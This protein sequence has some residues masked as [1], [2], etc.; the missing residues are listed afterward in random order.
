MIGDIL[1]ASRTIQ[2]QQQNQIDP[3]DVVT[4]FLILAAIVCI[5][6]LWAV[7]GAW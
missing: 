1:R 2:P 7:A 5:W 4:A 6:A 3:D